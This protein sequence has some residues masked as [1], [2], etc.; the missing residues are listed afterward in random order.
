MAQPTMIWTAIV[1]IAKGATKRIK[2]GDKGRGD[3]EGIRVS[4]VFNGA[5]S[6]QVAGDLSHWRSECWVACIWWFDHLQFDPAENWTASYSDQVFPRPKSLLLPHTFGFSFPVLSP[7]WKV[8]SLTISIIFR[9]SSSISSSSSEGFS[10]IE[11]LSGFP[12][13]FPTGLEGFSLVTWLFETHQLSYRARMFSVLSWF[14]SSVS[15]HL[16]WEVFHQVPI[17]DFYSRFPFKIS[18]EVL[19]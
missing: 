1:W 10:S 16:S 3:K 8:F 7:G 15:N 6:R 19:F 2:W 14:F 12:P 5:R 9:F 18:F 11:P 13:Q 17:Q 4:L